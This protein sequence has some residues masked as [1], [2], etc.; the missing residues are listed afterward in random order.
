M[1]IK[2]FGNANIIEVECRFCGK[3]M[4][5][6]D[7]LLSRGEIRYLKRL[8]CCDECRNLD[9]VYD[10]CYECGLPRNPLYRHVVENGGVPKQM[11]KPNAVCELCQEGVPLIAY[12]SE[13]ISEYDVNRNR[14]LNIIKSYIKPLADL[15]GCSHITLN[16]R[17]KII[18]ESFNAIRND[19]I[20]LV[21][22]KDKKPNTEI[23]FYNCSKEVQDYL[24]AIKYTK[25]LGIVDW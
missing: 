2:G 10:T 21:A 6:T 7:K 18:R 16:I 14:E 19:E 12:N 5:F 8:D 11:Y 9:E 13:P 20:D 1:S 22:D 3:D 15:P 25:V 24:K 4:G 17:E 23:D